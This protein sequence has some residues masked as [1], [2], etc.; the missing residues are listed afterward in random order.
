VVYT[1][2]A[3]RRHDVE[4]A[5]AE[6]D[7]LLSVYPSLGYEVI[8]LPKVGVSERADFVLQRLMDAPKDPAS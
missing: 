3:K 6:Y 5:I 7:R 4:A 2:D 8:V 1:T